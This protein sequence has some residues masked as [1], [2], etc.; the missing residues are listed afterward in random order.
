MPQYRK[1]H[2][3]ATESFDIAEMPDDFTRLMWVFLPL[4][5]CSKGRGIDRASW[6]MGQLFPLRTDIT[7]QMVEA[8]MSWYASRDMIQRYEVGGRSY[9]Q[10]TKWD[11]YQGSTEREAPSQYP[12]PPSVY[13]TH[14]QV[15]PTVS[16]AADSTHEQVMSRSSLDVD[17][18]AN[19]KIDAEEESFAAFAAAPVA[20]PSADYAEI[21]KAW[22]EIF[23]KKPQPRPVNKTLQGKVKTRMSDHYFRGNWL[24]AMQ[25]A[26]QSLF[27]HQSSWFDLGWFLKNDENWLK[28]L[29]GNYDEQLNGNG[30]HAATP[31]GR[32]LTRTEQAGMEWAKRKADLL[33]IGQGGS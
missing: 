19:T 22:G 32:R 2:T 33:S 18:N 10:I 3:K 30:Q 12:P 17:A 25:R 4:K 11:T 14:E 23:P 1:L 9:Y 24:Q 28:C 13:T 20:S 8:A 26:G 31:T 27:L 5:S 15:L 7:S 6:I 29:N 21:V 16:P